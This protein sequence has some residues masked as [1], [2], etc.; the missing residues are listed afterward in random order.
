MAAAAEMTSCPP[1][2]FQ[3][4]FSG[5]Q[6]RAP[7]K[8]KV[9]RWPMAP[10]R[11]FGIASRTRPAKSPTARSGD[12]ACD[13]YRRFVDDVRLDARTW[14]P[15]YRFSI[16]WSRVLPAGIGKP[17]RPGLDFY[18][19]LVDALVGAWNR[20]DGHALPLGLAA[21]A[22]GSRRLGELGVGELVCRIRRGHVP[23]AG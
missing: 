11:A 18:S 3:P 15:A 8:S 23:Q 14:D 10:A 19:R 20:T 5:A 16:S 4:T 12:V 13:H 21:G 6:R 2:R 17:N 7:I 9:R 1:K 22:R